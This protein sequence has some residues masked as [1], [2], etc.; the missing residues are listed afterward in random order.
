MQNSPGAK[1]LGTWSLGEA[2]DPT[3]NAFGLLRCLLATLVIASHC[4]PIG[5]FGADPLESMTNRRLSIGL[6]SVALFF[7]LSG[8]LITRSALKTPS[9]GRFLWHRFLRIFPG[10]WV[11]LI[12]C[13][14]AVAPI[15][16][17]IESG[18]VLEIFSLRV[19]SPQAY[20]VKNLCMFHLNGFSIP[21]V[22]NIE[23]RRIG[24]MMAHNPCRFLINGSLWTLPYEWFCYLAIAVLATMSILRRARVALLCFLASSWALYS[25]SWASP[26]VFGEWFPYRCIT[27]FV[28]LCLYFSA[29]SVSY[30]YREKIRFSHTLIMIAVIFLVGA[31]FMGWFGVIAPL[32]LPYLFLW[33]GCKLPIHRF[34]AHGDYS[35]GLYLYA[36]PV[37]QMLVSF[38]VQEKGFAFYFLEATL[39]TGILAFLSYRCVEAPCLKLKHISLQGFL[40]NF[41][42][43]SRC[44]DSPRLPLT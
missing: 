15:V 43:K 34:D 23:P 30:L 41:A 10:Y 14:F 38:H 12:V 42:I 44:P 13:A 9:V 6:L 35:Y 36:F 17:E 25:F 2:F 20:V 24:L 33:L 40:E 37:Q 18:S 16:Y 21:G 19:E 5:G 32:A 26:R 22:M 3:K 29:G 8:F 1:I 11:C 39:L 27:E 31:L 28:M 7:V 4:Y